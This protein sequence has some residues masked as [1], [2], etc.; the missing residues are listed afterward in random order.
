MSPLRARACASPV[1]PA[2][3]SRTITLLM[4]ADRPAGQASVRPSRR[5][6]GV[7]R[8]DV[9]S[10]QIASNGTSR[11]IN[12][13]IVLELI[14]FHQPVSRVELA[15]VS[16]LQPSTVSEIVEQLL[17]EGWICEGAVVRGPRGRPSTMLSVNDAILMFAL[18]I[19]PD[20]AIVA[21]VDLAG[22][23]LLRES[24]M[25]VSDPEMSMARVIQRM[26]VLRQSYPTYRFEGIGVSV[27]GRVHPETQQLLLAPNLHW[28]GFDIR[29]ALEDGLDLQV[30]IENDANACLLSEC[31]SGRL[32]NIQHAVLVA[33]SEG[34]GTG[35]LAGGQL[36]SGYNGL[37]GEF[38]HVQVDPEG[39]LCGCG[40][41]GCWEMVASSRAAIMTYRELSGTQDAVD[42]YTLLRLTEEGNSAAIEAVSRQAAAIGRGLRLIVA[43]LSPEL[44][45]MTGE[46]TSVWDRFGPIIQGH[47]ERYTLAGAAPR[48]CVAGDGE[49]ARLQGAAAVLLHA[50]ADYLRSAHR[51]S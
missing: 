50:H 44:I 15:R 21:I 22:R 14:R 8:I 4:G 25:T 1:R 10:V 36:H 43:S 40:Q 26:L 28:I 39:P 7:R 11:T 24:I 29:K 34:I 48:L 35:V 49:S 20:R 42:I 45:L 6:S 16:G 46:I 5:L 23:F 31:W 33:V 47:L 32:A 27:P 38:G 37:A 3:V 2:S 41:R 30:E 51:V 17:Q 12:R 19:R 13:N 18:D 9:A